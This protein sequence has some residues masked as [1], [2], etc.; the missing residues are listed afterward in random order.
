M[1][2]AGRYVLRRPGNR[3]SARTALARLVPAAPKSTICQL[4]WP[5][6]VTILQLRRHERDDDR[7]QDQGRAAESEHQQEPE[8]EQYGEGIHGPEARNS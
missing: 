7:H 5:T 8:R 1:Q 2:K 3:Q 4:T 6:L